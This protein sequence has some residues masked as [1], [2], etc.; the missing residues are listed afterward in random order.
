MDFVAG[1]LL[2]GSGCGVQLSGMGLV[3]IAANRV[4]LTKKVGL[5]A[6]QP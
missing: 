3:R 2:I 6:R 1:K 5:R 4:G